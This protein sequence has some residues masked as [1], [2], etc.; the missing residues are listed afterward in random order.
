MLLCELEQAEIAHHRCDQGVIFQSALLLEVVCEQ[1]EQLVAIYQCAVLVHRQAP[2]GIPVERQPEVVAAHPHFARQLFNMGRT[3]VPVD[4]Q[5]VR[6]GAEDGA[7]GPQPFKQLFRSDACAAVG[8]V[9]RQPHPR[10]PAREGGFQVIHI[11]VRR[12]RRERDRPDLACGLD[13]VRTLPVKNDPFDLLFLFV[14]QLKARAAEE[15]NAVVFIGI[16]ARREH[17]ARL[18][19]VPG[20][21]ISDRRGWHHADLDDICACAAKP[22][23]DRRFE[24]IRRNPGVFAD[25]EGRLAAGL[26]LH[27]HARRTPDIGCKPDREVP[28]CDPTYPIRSKNSS[29]TVFPHPM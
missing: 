10:K 12:P 27:D 14:T 11:I 13:A 26:L 4:V 17:H 5:P 16:V 7:F 21:K 24:H 22:C 20:Y 25:Q 15:F 6:L 2:V 1:R 8:T 23:R 9:D 18:C 28:I 3:T 19:A 29:H